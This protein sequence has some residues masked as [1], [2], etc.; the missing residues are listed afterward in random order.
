MFKEIE[1]IYLLPT[2]FIPP[3][4]PSLNRR[5]IDRISNWTLKKWGGS[6]TRRCEYVCVNNCLPWN[7]QHP[8]HKRAP[9]QTHTHAISRQPKINFQL[10]NSN[11]LRRKYNRKPIYFPIITAIYHRIG[12]LVFHARS[13]FPPVR[14]VASDSSTNEAISG[15]FRRGAAAHYCLSL[16]HFFP[17]NFPAEKPH[18][19]A[20]R[21]AFPA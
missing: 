7:E 2:I 11:L 17:L 14:V 21:R 13:K 5:T 4:F 20:R 8:R 19:N 1:I 10:D 9:K 12:N 18:T 15:S 6:S 16:S 3:T